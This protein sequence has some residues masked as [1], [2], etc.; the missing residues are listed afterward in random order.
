MKKNLNIIQIKGV[1]GLIYVGFVL[2]CL[3]AGFIFFPG[4]AAMKIWNFASS[5][6]EAL[7]QIGIIQG[8]LL[9]GIIAASYFI[10]RKEK[11]VICM[12]A[13][14][15]LSEEELKE[16]FTDL[17]KHAQ[18]DTIIKSMLK[19]HEAELRIRNLEESDIPKVENKKEETDKVEIK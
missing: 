8:L 10:F 16:V 9:W 17:K 3:A 4:F 1:K 6:I 2:T 19:A 18:N 11:L 7:P 12:K 13:E 14:D 5:Y 15:G